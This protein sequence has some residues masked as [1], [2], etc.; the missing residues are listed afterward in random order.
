MAFTR[1][2]SSSF[3]Y[4]YLKRKTSFF[5]STTLGAIY[6]VLF[7]NILLLKVYRVVGFNFFNSFNSNLIDSALLVLAFLLQI[8]PYCCVK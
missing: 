5:Q 7:F 2:F 1:A 4:F 6:F 3:P 8:Q